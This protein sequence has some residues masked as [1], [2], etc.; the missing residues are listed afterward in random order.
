M[1]MVTTVPQPERR[2]QSPSQ[3]PA[4]HRRSLR[5]VRPAPKRR[6]QP[7]H[8][9]WIIGPVLVLLTLLSVA[10]GQTVLTEGQVS[11]STLQSQVSAAQT[12]RLDLE[13]QVAQEEQPSAVIAAAT[14]DGMVVPTEI[15]ELPAVVTTPTT[16]GS[17]DSSSLSANKHGDDGLAATKARSGDS[18]ENSA[19]NRATVKH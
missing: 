4:E 12:K 9:A 1:T 3:A 19:T 13:L 17:L 11:L 16:D 8:R 7:G 18:G 2:A 10:A 5:V 15:N 14:R 6:S